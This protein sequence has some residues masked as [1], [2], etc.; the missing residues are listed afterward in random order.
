MKAP[1][2]FGTRASR[3]A[4]W[5]THHVAHALG[6]AHP[7]LAWAE[8]VIETAGDEDRHTPL[9]EIG[10][11]GV[12]TEALEAALLRGEI[13]L[14][15]HSLKDLPIAPASGLDVGAVC[16]RADARDA[17]VAR[18][19]WTL[20]S[21]P[22]SAVIGT[23]SLRRTGQLKGLRPDLRF[24]PLRGNV[25]TRVRA[26]REGKYDAVCIAA[27][28]VERLGLGEAVSEYLPFE[29][30]LPAPGQGALAVQCR[31]DDEAMRRLLLAIDDAAVRAA[32]SA[33]RAF[34]AGVGGGCSAPVGAFGRVTE[35]N[36][37]LRLDAVAAAVDGTIVIRV[38][39]TGSV[40][41]PTDLGRRLAEEALARGA[42]ALVT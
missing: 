7:G 17:L 29:R 40:T 8:I 24:E 35:T 31:A 5:Q 16:F 13:D 38:N 22:E 12:F 14:A 30:L 10:G 11:K 15:V 4:R 39:G 34:L 26:A 19:R 33:E 1:V 37:A 21:L 9:P 18:E 6:A 41:S 23:S 36:R 27:A 2:R 42:G 32:V 25:D 3:L 28:G 20:D